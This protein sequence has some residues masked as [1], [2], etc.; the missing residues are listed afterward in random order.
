MYSQTI[1]LIEKKLNVLL[2]KRQECD[3]IQTENSYIL[4]SKYNKELEDLVLDFTTSNPETLSYKFE[5]LKNGL[6]IISSEDG[7]F[8]IYSWNTLEGG[9]MQY[10]KN[11]F[12]YNV[13]GKT[14]S[15]SS[16]GILNNKKNGVNFLEINDLKVDSKRYYVTTSISIGSSALYY[17]EAKVFALENG[18]LNEN[19]KLIKTK[20]GIKNTLGYEVDLSSSANRDRTDGL[21]TED[22]IRLI[23]D[24]KNRIIIIPLINGN[25]LVT[26]NKIKYKFEKAYF[27]RI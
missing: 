13:D 23:Y 15:K 16:N 7:Q 1:E 22:F 27:E 10:Y 11:V 17:Y 18:K 24:K 25:G 26:K 21:E 4:L 6:N 8:R 14:Y 2:E 5:N 12:Q 9:S 20:S 19:A 3:T